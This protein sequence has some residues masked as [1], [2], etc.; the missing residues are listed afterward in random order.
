MLLIFTSDEL[1]RIVASYSSKAP[2]IEFLEE[3]H[4]KIKISGMSVSLFLEDVQPRKISFIYKMS[5]MVNFFVDK[6]V[7]FDKPGIIW[8]KESGRISIDFAQLIQDKNINQ[9]YIKQLLFDKEKMVLS[10]DMNNKEE[11]KNA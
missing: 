9:F 7:N 4:L 1:E 8:D 6:F 3:N 11:I 5:P 2:K 10:F